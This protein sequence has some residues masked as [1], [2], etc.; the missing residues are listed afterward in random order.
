MALQFNGALQVDIPRV[1][2]NGDFSISGVF[3]WTDPASTNIMLGDSV[4]TVSNF[5]GSS[6]SDRMQFKLGATTVNVVSSYVIGQLYS[7]TATRTGSTLS[8]TVDGVT[9]TGSSPNQVTFDVFGQGGSGSRCS[10]IL[11]GNWV[12]SGDGISTRTYD[13]NQN[14]GDTVLPD[15]TS[16][17]DGVITGDQTGGGF[18]GGG[19][20]I[21][22]TSIDDYECRQRDANNQAI[23]T[24]AGTTSS[25]AATVEYSLDGG[26]W[27]ILDA[28]PSPTAFTG[29]VIIT[30]QQDIVVRYSDS[31][32]TTDS[33][34]KVSAAACVP[35]TWQS[36]AQ[37]KGI[38]NQVYSVGA[39]QPIMYKDSS[40]QAITDPTGQEPD[41]EGS[42]WPRVAKRFA[43]VGIVLCVRNIAVGG[44]KIVDWQK[45]SGLYVGVT[46][47]FNVVGGFEFTVSVGG[48]NDAGAG[49]SI[50]TMES[51]LTQ[52]CTDLNT[53]FGST[54]YLTYFPVG[55]GLPASSTNIQNIRT[56]FDNVISD[57]SFIR[58]GGDLITID[59]DTGP[60]GNDGIHLRQDS[61]LEVGGDIVFTALHGSQLTF[62]TTGVPDGNYDAVMWD[63]SRT[64]V[65]NGVLSVSSDTFSLLVNADIGGVIRGDAYDPVG[66]DDDGFRI[67]GITS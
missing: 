54:H 4:T 45:G 61:D 49:T 31:I 19:D 15:T 62:I 64:I 65:F 39:I 52:F 50:A 63:D 32:T 57:N 8:C 56:S 53:D 21:S 58:S 40:F 7:F 41:S 26:S 66:A 22:I 59:I 44:T 14:P 43:D 20:V 16:S 13:F 36:N 67:L 37:G 18:V 25:Q 17:E 51:L 6:N 46:D 12:I 35:I 38:N 1:T 60:V 28:S 10:A 55:N 27:L 48:E 42:M 47:F 34:V 2:L 11:D 33:K 23:F 9:E 30:G 5:I 29:N 3:E 24:I